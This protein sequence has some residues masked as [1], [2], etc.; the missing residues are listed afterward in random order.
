MSRH[1]PEIDGLRA[2]AVLSVIFYHYLPAAFPGGFV[3]VDVFFV[4]SGYLI[5]GRIAS[6]IGTNRFSLL[7]FYE[8][9]IRR[10][11]PALAL[12][13]VLVLLS[14]SLILFPRDWHFQSRVAA[15]V[16]PFLGNY[17][18]YQNA[19]AYGGEF[20]SHIPLL[21]TWSLA[22]EEQF[23][24]FFPLLMLAI[25]RFARGRYSTVLWILTL[26]SFVLCVTGVRVAPLATF[27]L[28]Q[29]RAW[30][31]LLGA[32]LAVGGFSPPGN[33]SVRGV[34]TLSGLLL[35][36]GADLFLRPTTPNPS[37]YTLLPCIGAV[38]ILY[39]ASDKTMPAGRLLDNRIMRRI[40]L[41]SYSLYLAHW[42][43]LV[44]AEYYAFDPLSALARGVLLAATFVIGALS[45]RY[46]EQPFRGS[47]ALLGRTTLYAVAA[48][49]ALVLLSATVAAYHWSD[50]RRYGPAERAIFATNTP[51][52]LQCQ[53][54][55]PERTQRP[56][57]RL[58]DRGAPVEAI[59]WGDS[60]AS[61]LP[62]S[63]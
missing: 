13:Y 63:S 28:P 21:H 44:L 30:E 18:L 53:N 42:P 36:A 11:V 62:S 26:L 54:T 35:I 9:R 1:R 23:Y 40:G 47:D 16:I 48:A 6:E 46:V 14:S 25:Q 50:P 43:L 33:A 31:L 7:E 32:L 29:F 34:M 22:V 58:G 41:W 2:I 27:Y 10:I 52:Q 59:L 51:R 37:E 60:H 4:I 3:G 24:L 55:S 19:G 12:M 56:P 57:C 49:V 17:A 5:T 8:R 38:A 61:R 20:A 39:A 15:Y 45:W